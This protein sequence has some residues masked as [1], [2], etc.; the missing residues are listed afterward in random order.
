MAVPPSYVT[1]GLN[2]LLE[3]DVP[4]AVAAC[5]TAAIIGS[6]LEK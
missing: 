6:V 5:K 3:G 1:R 2:K 4:I